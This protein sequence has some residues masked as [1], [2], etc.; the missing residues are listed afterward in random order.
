MLFK[1]RTIWYAFI[2]L[3]ALPIAAFADPISGAIAILG[4]LASL[5]QSAIISAAAYGLGRLASA[6]GGKPKPTEAGR[7]DIRINASREGEPI[8]RFYGRFA[9]G[10][11]VIYAG[12][13]PTFNRGSSSGGKRRTTTPGFYSASFGV[14]VCLND[15]NNVLGVSAVYLNGELKYPDDPDLPPPLDG[16]NSIIQG[17]AN[18]PQVQCGGARRFQIILG[19]EDAATRC[20]WYKNDIM[21]KGLG[22]APDY[23]PAY[24]GLVT[25]WWDDLALTDYYNQL[26]QVLVEVQMTDGSFRHIIQAEAE[27]AGL[28]PDTQVDVSGIGAFIGIPGMFAD[29]P[30]PP[31]QLF[32][33]MGFYSRFVIVEADGVQKAFSLPTDS[34][35]AVPAGDLGAYLGGIEDNAEKP[36][37]TTL[38]MEQ[39][40]SLPQRVE[41]SYFD[42]T[43]AYEQASRGYSRQ[44]GGAKGTQQLFL[45]MALAADQARNIASR[46]I[47]VAYAEGDPWKGVLPPKYA[48]YHPGDV[49]TL[50]EPDGT[51]IDVRIVRM[52]FAPGGPVEIEGIRQL[53]LT[54]GGTPSDDPHL[55]PEDP[56]TEAVVYSAWVL[57]PVPPLVDDHD[58]FAGLYWGAA[59]VTQPTSRQRSWTGGTLYQNKAG[60]D[61]TYKEYQAIARTGTAATLGVVLT[62]LADVSGLDTT[63]EIDIHLP[64]GAGDVAIVGILDDAFTKTTVVNLCIVGKEILQF[65]DVEDVSDLYGGDAG[66]GT[67]FRLTHLKR[68]LRGTAHLTGSHAEDEPFLMWS[69]YSCIRVPL[70]VDEHQNTWSFKTLSDGQELTAIDPPM[71]FS[72]E[73]D[74]PSAIKEGNS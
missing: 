6:I 51:Y 35:V 5:A 10:G 15:F 4:G 21:A 46:V 27:L 57:A 47:S 36:A 74:G 31:K 73:Y 48:E 37:K 41:V 71:Y 52:N 39:P 58:G 28:D 72:L 49:L 53:R 45:P 70:N 69:A 34:S 19:N 32:E 59:P 38:S 25:L 63:S 65:R 64:Y 23:V 29:G 8:R 61:E 11:H 9:G 13:P 62:E 56:P 54:G 16:T 26:P 33:A 43:N 3:L 12:S 2:V 55:D 20:E 44:S 1:R 24:R 60:S 42:A 40:E 7:Q 17:V 30:T 50:P 67:H 66:D 18:G 14:A 22:P 68:G